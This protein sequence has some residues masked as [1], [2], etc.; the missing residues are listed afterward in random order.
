[1]SDSNLGNRSESG[2]GELA[3]SMRARPDYPRMR[4]LPKYRV[5]L[6]NDDVHEVV[7]VIRT[8]VELTPLDVGQAKQVTLVAH[9]SGL[10]QVLVT[11]KERAELYREQLQSRGL[12]ST[13]E[14]M[15]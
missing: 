13:I 8:L 12:R 3:R 5:L 11:H 4:E 14:P 7:F 2:S 15:D 1:M 6:H 9:T 10:A